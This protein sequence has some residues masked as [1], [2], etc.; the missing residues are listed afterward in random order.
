MNILQSIC[1][2][3]SRG[4]GEQSEPTTT[5]RNESPVAKADLGQTEAGLE[6]S[7]KEQMGHMQGDEAQKPA[8]R[9]P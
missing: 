5:R 4:C 1:C 7:G 6:K 2:L 3:F 8:N 9:Q